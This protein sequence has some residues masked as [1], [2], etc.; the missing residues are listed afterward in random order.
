MRKGVGA[1]YFKMESIA[2]FSAAPQHYPRSGQE[3]RVKEGED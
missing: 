2:A 3:Q 1:F